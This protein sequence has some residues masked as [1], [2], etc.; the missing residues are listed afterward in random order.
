MRKTHYF[1]TIHQ[2]RDS[3]RGSLLSFFAFGAAHGRLIIEV[4]TRSKFG[5]RYFKFGSAV[6]VTTL[7]AIYPLFSFIFGRSLSDHW[8]T[9]YKID[10]GET[11][12]SLLLFIWQYSGWYVFLFYFMMKSIK[13]HREIV[14]SRSSFDFGRFSKSNGEIHPLFFNIKVPGLETNYRTVE[15]YIEPLGFFLGGIVLAII[16]QKLGFIFIV[17]SIVYCLSYKS[18]YLEGDNYILD[19]IDNK[20]CNEEIERAF[21]DGMDE[22]DTRG[23]RVRARKP[24]DKETRRKVVDLMEDDEDAI[25]AT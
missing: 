23:F 18:A 8:I 15:C 25:V 24:E 13:H 17:S 3:L 7:L 16:G 12:F 14:K 10:H 20:I 11:D 2:N 9:A 19:L 5:E 21:V 22:Q 1:R 4:F 6:A